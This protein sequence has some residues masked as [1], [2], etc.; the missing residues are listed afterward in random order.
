MRILNLCSHSLGIIPS[1]VGFPTSAHP[2]GL[3]NI[4]LFLHQSTEVS[5]CVKGSRREEATHAFSL[6]VK[7]NLRK[8]AP[9]VLFME[10]RQVEHSFCLVSWTSILG[11]VTYF[12]QRERLVSFLVRMQ[13]PC[14][15]E[16]QPFCCNYPDTLLGYRGKQ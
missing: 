8:G 3:A 12:N 4:F 15:V 14:M 16:V 2:I 11:E 5:L 13:A 1:K 7:R 6:R 10:L 9:H